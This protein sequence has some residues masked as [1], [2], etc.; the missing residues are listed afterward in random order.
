MGE[1]YAAIQRSGRSACSG[2]WGQSD[3]YSAGFVT[4]QSIAFKYLMAPEPYKYT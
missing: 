2:G 3:D 4:T 1:G